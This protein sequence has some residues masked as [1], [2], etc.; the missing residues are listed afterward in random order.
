MSLWLRT[1]GALIGLSGVLTAVLA[2]WHV[3]RDAAYAEAAAA[4]ARHPDHPLFQADYYVAAAR[5]FGLL[6]LVA[7]GLLVGLGGGSA[8][9]ALADLVRR[10]GRR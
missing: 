1:L 4:Y 3:T 7:L 8:L 6:T 10:V 2:G 9:I 5:H